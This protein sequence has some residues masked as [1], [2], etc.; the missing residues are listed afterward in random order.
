[1]T[2]FFL[3]LLV[4]ASTCAAQGGF[5]GPGRYTIINVKSGKALQAAG[6]YIAQNNQNGSPG[7][8]WT[9]SPAGRGGM[10]T[11]QNS[12]NGCA[13]TLGGQGNSI[14]V[15]CKAFRQGPNQLWS[16][17]PGKDGNPLIVAQNGK[18]LDIPNG[19]T[20]AG[21]RVQTYDRNGDDNQRFYFQR[22]GG[23]RPPRY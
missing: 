7:Q 4:W 2:R 11:I 21:T 6:H 13:L 15:Q 16:L 18:V 9:V 8:M 3:L 17:Q 12:M 14:P 1:M 5:A 22:A 23:G 20:N 10:V 19:N